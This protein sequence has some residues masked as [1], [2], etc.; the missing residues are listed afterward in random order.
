MIEL[1][2]KIKQLGKDSIVYGLGYFFSKIINLALLPIYTRVFLPQEYGDIELIY[3]IAGFLLIVM[4]LGTDS[5]Q[6]YYFHKIAND[7]LDAQK[8]LITSIFQWRLVWG[9]ITVIF[10]CLI[11]FYPSFQHFHLPLNFKH[12]IVAFLGYLFSQIISQGS[13]IFRLLY[14]PWKYIL[15]NLLFSVG[16]S[17]F[18]LV[19]ILVFKMGLLGFWMGSLV[20]SIIFAIVTCVLIHPYLDFGKWHFE[21]WKNII[22][23]GAPL[24]QVGLVMYLLNSID[25]W[26]L[27]YFHGKESLGLYSVASRF[28][29]IISFLVTAFRQAWWPIA[30]E[31]LHK[32]FGKDLFRLIARLYLGIVSIGILFLTAFSA[33]LVTHMTGNLYHSSY[34]IIGILSWHSAFY[35]FY[36]ISN[37]GIW[38]SEK[39]WIS[40]ITVLIAAIS[41]II[42][43]YLLIP[44]YS[45]MGASI[46]ISLSFLIWNALEIY[47]SE[48]LWPIHYPFKI[49]FIQLFLGI[50]G[51]ILISLMLGHQ[52]PFWKVMILTFIFG[53]GVLYF[54]LKGVD[55]LNINE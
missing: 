40:S 27:S 47:F 15:I 13:D 6:S 10:M 17:L 42:L 44:R 28:V 16:S 55:R 35:G 14:K 19:F 37:A 7:G 41:N 48:K 29:M 31:A 1:K 39:T 36:L 25:R 38:K 23:F 33:F 54:T 49:F 53:S 9:I 30:V 4:N 20:G 11:L 22:K 52:Y 2:L 32:D 8:A 5:A 24:L 46:S 12:C 51:C 43:A 18:A 50:V 34:I 3:M 26:F 21:W 45:L